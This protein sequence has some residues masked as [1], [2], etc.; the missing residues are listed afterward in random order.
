M[1]N[2]KDIVI[3]SA[4]RTAIG[5]F[6]GNLSSISASELGSVVIKAI[7]NETGID[8]NIIDEV[9][10]GNVLSAGQGQAPARQ[11]A[12]SAGLP[13]KVEC[14]TINKMCGS[15]LKSVMLASHAIQ[16]GDA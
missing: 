4:K 13:S 11:A 12:I 8:P 3:V 15:G 9:I 5:S 10:M 6:Q 1:T 2:P 16:A 7:L 14:F